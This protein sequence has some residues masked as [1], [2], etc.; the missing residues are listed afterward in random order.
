M[1]EDSL[2]GHEHDLARPLDDPG[3]DVVPSLR[4]VSDRLLRQRIERVP[5]ARLHR[6]Q[7]HLWRHARGYFRLHQDLLA[8]LRLEADNELLI[9]Q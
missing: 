5:H 9:E 6:L 7:P 4:I 8:L 1:V 3:S 2:R